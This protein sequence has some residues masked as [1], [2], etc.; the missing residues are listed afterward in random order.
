MSKT[1]WIGIDVAKR[2]FH[3][4]VASVDSDVQQWPS[5]P[6][7]EFEH[8]LQ[9]MQAFCRW[10]AEQ[11]VQIAGICLE[12]TG[13]LGWGWMAL[14]NGGLCP[15]S[16][17]N[18]ARPAAYAKTLGL[19]DK[20][21]RVDACVLVLYGIATRPTPTPL[22][23]Q[24]MRPL[25]E[26]AGFYTHEMQ[27]FVACQNRMKEESLSKFVRRRLEETRVALRR[28][29]K[30]TEAEMD[31]LI[32][33]DQ[34]LK[35]QKE[36]IQSIP[37]V[38][39]KTARVIL[40]EFGDLREYR[41]NE[42]VALAG[43]YPRQF[44]SGQSIRR[45]PRLAKGGKPR[46]R[47]VLYMAAMAAWRHCPHLRRFADRLED[48]ALS[49]M[50]ILGALMRKLLLLIRAVAVTATQYDPNYRGVQNSS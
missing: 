41:R 42:L 1:I 23:S 12:A 21:D 11:K 3:A 10:V 29:L 49:K 32:E 17:V 50:A 40:A 6:T 31:R 44:Q 19:R 14:L 30:E 33:E 20:T 46:V 2:K 48:Q 28:S 26:L 34:V 15:V 8:T 47:A 24:R 4:A 38:T 35:Q 18:P 43:L 13:R 22:P 36:L 45:K 7:E 25:K 27:Q 5:F 37:G 9:G 16:L 39:S